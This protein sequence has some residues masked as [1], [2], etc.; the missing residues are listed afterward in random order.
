MPPSVQP[1]ETAPGQVDDPELSA[2]F[3]AREA[4]LAE[5]AVKG[6][7]VAERLRKRAIDRRIT[8]TFDDP[9][10]PEDPIRVEIHMP[11]AAEQEILLKCAED[12]QGSDPALAKT[13]AEK[14]I[15][16]VSNLLVDAS[17]TR[18]FWQSGAFAPAD[19]VKIVAAIV[20]E[21]DREVQEAI[22]F[23]PQR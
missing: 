11:T 21:T 10:N 6:R 13:A 5:Q 1:D 17:L 9:S 12:W 3:H 22:K 18:E 19:F 4:L 8:V 7:S 14:L 23:R 2:R 15:G 20:S 16:L